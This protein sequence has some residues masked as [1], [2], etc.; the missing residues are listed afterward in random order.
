MVLAIFGCL[1]LS[2]CRRI[3]YEKNVIMSPL[4]K[5]IVEKYLGEDWDI[6]IHTHLLR[7]VKKGVDPLNIK[8]LLGVVKINT[9]KGMEFNLSVT[10]CQN[11]N[12]TLD[13]YSYNK[14]T[15]KVEDLIVSIPNVTKVS[16][17]IKGNI[18]LPKGYYLPLL[19]VKGSLD[20]EWMNNIK[21]GF[22]G[23]K[24]DA[25]HHS[26]ETDI[27]Q[28]LDTYIE[29]NHPNYLSKTISNEIGVYPITPNVRKFVM[30]KTI[31]G[32]KKL[33]LIYTGKNNNN[34]I[35]SNVL[36]NRID[37]LFGDDDINNHVWNVVSNQTNIKI[38]ETVYNTHPLTKLNNFILIED[39]QN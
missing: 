4:N 7:P 22:R 38:I 26:L 2:F 14:R 28:D 20:R 32:P 11:K 36:G 9:M 12:C 33:T 29:N 25:I 3:I 18:S 8:D 31:E 10:S 21:V 23:I 16:S 5:R 19:R 39:E 15:N 13:F 1:L 30:N 27:R 24:C 34:I 35:T 6:D 17:G 37:E